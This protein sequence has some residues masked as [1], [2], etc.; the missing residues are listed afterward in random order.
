MAFD[1]TAGS[2]VEIQP[3]PT[4]QGNG[5]SFELTGTSY[6]PSPPSDASGTQ[7]PGPA[8]DIT[9]TPGSENIEG[10]ILQIRAGLANLTGHLGPAHDEKIECVFWKDER[11]KVRAKARELASVFATTLSSRTMS[12]AA[13]DIELR[14]HSTS[15]NGQ[16]RGA[17]P[18]N[19]IL[20]APP[21]FSQEGWR[22]DP[23]HLEA[24]LGLWV[25]SML[26]D[27]TM[28]HKE[29]HFEQEG[30]HATR[31]SRAERVRTCRIVPFG[32]DDSDWQNRF[33]AQDNMDLWFGRSSV[34]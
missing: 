17:R 15:L 34:R 9:P 25:W 29:F 14:V 32:P 19:F 13:R 11:V 7:E 4:F 10:H 20:R 3:R 30:E 8:I 2:G 1:S 5:G 16:Y 12:V 21:D 26:F 27:K 22:S 24:L 31:I 33:D 28:V 18:I 23:A 6:A